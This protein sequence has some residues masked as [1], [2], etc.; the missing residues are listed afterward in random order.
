MVNGDGSR[1]QKAE[2][3]EGTVRTCDP[4][5]LATRPFEKQEGFGMASNVQLAS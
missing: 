3:K 4:K 5:A 1:D 2:V